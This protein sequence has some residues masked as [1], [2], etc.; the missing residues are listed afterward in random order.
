MV[1][2][3]LSFLKVGGEQFPRRLRVTKSKDFARVHR[4]NVFAADSM[5]VVR[6]SMNHRGHPRLGLSVSR[7]VG[8][9]PLRN[10]W[11]RLIR[12]AF[13]TMQFELPAGYDLVVRPRRGADPSLSEI[14]RSLPKLARQIVRKWERKLK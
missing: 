14:R 7:K 3:D 9:A 5:L 11:K 2:D 8:H 4:H 1:Q 10:Q 12:E 13:R 6:G